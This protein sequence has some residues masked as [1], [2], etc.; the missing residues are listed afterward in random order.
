MSFVIDPVLRD[1]SNYI[2]EIRLNYLFKFFEVE[3]T[4]QLL[5]QIIGQVY[6]II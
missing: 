2:L 4:L 5:N 3:T 1:Y 6:Y